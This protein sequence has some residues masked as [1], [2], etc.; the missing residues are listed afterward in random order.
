MLNFFH[1]TDNCLGYVYF[2]KKFTKLLIFISYFWLDCVFF[3]ES[4]NTESFS[5]IELLFF[6]IKEIKIREERR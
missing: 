3:V 1:M 4:S 2:L 5:H 6:I